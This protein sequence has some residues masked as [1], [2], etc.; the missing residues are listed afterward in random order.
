MTATPPPREYW[1]EEL[2]TLQE[3][4]L[5]LKPDPI[6][7]HYFA[8]KSIIDEAVEMIIARDEERNLRFFIN[9]VKTIVSILR[10]L[11]L[12]KDEVRIVCADR[13]ENEK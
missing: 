13:E 12:N 11:H 2:Q 8:C 5:D 9:S 10:R 6:N 4:V 1:F 7:L 3:V